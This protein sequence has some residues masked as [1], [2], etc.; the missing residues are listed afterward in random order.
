M[1]ST[2]SELRRP[3]NAPNVQARSLSAAD[4]ESGEATKMTDQSIAASSSA[5]SF[6]PPPSPSVALPLQRSKTTLTTRVTHPPASAAFTALKSQDDER[7]VGGLLGSIA[8]WS[9]CRIGMQSGLTAR[10]RFVDYEMKPC[11]HSRQAKHV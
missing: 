5:R 2:H 9:N 11:C 3:S 6:F 7:S 4:G 10:N 1:I 8:L